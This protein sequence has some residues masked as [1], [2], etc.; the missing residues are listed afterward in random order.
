[1]NAIEQNVVNYPIR[2]RGRKLEFFE[3]LDVGRVQAQKA[4]QTLSINQNKL[5]PLIPMRENH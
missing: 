2:Q 5:R 3:S 4:L 1:M